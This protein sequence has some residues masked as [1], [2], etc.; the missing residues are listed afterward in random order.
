MPDN[1]KRGKWASHVRQCFH[2]MLAHDDVM[3][4]LGYFGITAD[5]IRE[6]IEKIEAAKNAMFDHQMAQGISQQTTLDRKKVFKQLH[7]A[8]TVLKTVLKYALRGHGSLMATLS[9]LVDP[10]ED[11]ATGESTKQKLVREMGKARKKRR[12][13]ERKRQKQKKAKPAKSQTPNPPTPKT[14]T[15]KAPV[16]PNAATPAHPKSSPTPRLP[17]SPR[18]PH[19]CLCPMLSP[20]KG[21]CLST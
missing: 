16:P 2:D 5:H 7:D 19:K 6:A 9:G 17:H 1:K 15:P 20:R 4:A 18:I 21:Y 3:E 8:M 14:D 11:T 13:R 10:V 12:A